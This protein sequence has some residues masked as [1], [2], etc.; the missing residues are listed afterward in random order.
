MLGAYFFCQKTKTRGTVDVF[1]LHIQVMRVL[2]SSKRRRALL[3]LSQFT[4]FCAQL[5]VFTCGR[6]LFYWIEGALRH[7][8]YLI[9][10][11]SLLRSEGA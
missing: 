9:S 3:L 2:I 7:V 5:Y 8:F 1:F 6:V 4:L 10:Y 11:L